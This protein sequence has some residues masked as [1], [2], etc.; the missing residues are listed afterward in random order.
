MF[1]KLKPMVIVKKGKMIDEDVSNEIDRIYQLM[2]D[3]DPTDEKYLKLATRLKYLREDKNQILK[4]E[5]K[6]KKN[7][8]VPDGV[9]AGVVTGLFSLAGIVLIR[10]MEYDGPIGT[11]ALN[12]VQRNH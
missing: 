7:R 9:K 8:K 5:E 12:W 6:K 1:E 2:R 4:L 11:K 10:L 3:M